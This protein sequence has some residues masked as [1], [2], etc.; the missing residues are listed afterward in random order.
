MKTLL[1]SFGI[2]LA[3]L[4]Q[5]ILAEPESFKPYKG[6]PEFERIKSLVG[7]WSGKMDHG[8]G[9]MDINVEYRVVAGGSAVEERVFAGTPMEMI[10]MYHDKNGKLS[11]THFCMLHNQPSMILESSDKNTIKMKF[12][13]SC[14]ID[15]SKE[16]HMNALTLTF[17]ENG[18]LTHDW[19]MLE[20][21]KKKNH[22]PFVLTRVKK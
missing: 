1:L 6:S 10:T 20:G 2:I 11:L 21:G 4:A 13:P 19:T 17:H 12:D 22:N 15:A 3:F 8:N 7:K 5:S 18:T 16:P 9:P 14:G